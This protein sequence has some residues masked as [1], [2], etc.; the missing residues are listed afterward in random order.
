MVS[1]H[2]ESFSIYDLIKK[3][4]KITEAEFIRIVNDI[5]KDRDIIQ[6]H[7]PLGTPD[8]IMLWMLMSCLV[9]YLSLSNLEIPC[10]P[11]KPDADTYR[12]A[13]TYVLKDRKSDSFDEL[14]YLAELVK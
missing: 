9:S 1:I 11:G 7:N 4:T 10:F 6:K 3:M 12:T 5:Y 14:P 8:E 2:C 13:I